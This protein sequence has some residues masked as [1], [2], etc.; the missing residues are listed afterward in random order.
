MFRSC[1]VDT[2]LCILFIK[3]I[4]NMSAQ[5]DKSPRRCIGVVWLFPGGP[6]PRSWR[7]DGNVGADV[8][9]DQDGVAGGCLARS[10]AASEPLGEGFWPVR[11]VGVTPAPRSHPT[12]R[13]TARQSGIGLGM[14]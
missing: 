12:G 5:A 8:I 6:P 9:G 10:R 3:M 1:Q 4:E 11:G 14:R 13:A 2:F 7:R